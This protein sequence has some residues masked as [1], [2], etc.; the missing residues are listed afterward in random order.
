MVSFLL[1]LDFIDINTKNIQSKSFLTKALELK[2]FEV[3]TMLISDT[4]IQVEENDL[5]FALEVINKK[6]FSEFI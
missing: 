6:L 1:S 2:K 3:A 4:A 5:N